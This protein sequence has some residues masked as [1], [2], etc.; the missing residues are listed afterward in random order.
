[1]DLEKR[2]ISEGLKRMEV[3]EFLNRELSRAGYVRSELLK[4]PIGTRIVIYAERPSLVIGRRGSRIREVARILEKRFGIENPQIDVI[5]IQNPELNAKIMAYRIA[6]AMARG[7]R[8]RRAAFIAL[9]QIKEAGAIGAEIVISG[10]L[11]SE[12]ARFEKYRFGVILKS[13]KPREL[14]VDEAMVEVLLKPG[15]YGIKVKIMAP[16]PILPGQIEVKEIK[17]AKEVEARAVEAEGGGVA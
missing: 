4:T 1:L 12:R 9:R 15:V 3:E 10:K 5:Q 17:E 14:Y 13:G 8:F 16:M 2:I 7:V 6:R 11:T